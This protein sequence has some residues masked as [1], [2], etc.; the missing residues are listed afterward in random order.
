[1]EDHIHMLVDIHPTF[2]LSGFMRD[3]KESTSKWLKQNPNF[4]YF[5]YWAESF[6][7]FTYNLNDKEKI[8]N[9]IKNQKEHHK[10]ISF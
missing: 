5:D 4:P 3:L 6:A 8:I 2:S 9:Y 1:M 7:A 10:T